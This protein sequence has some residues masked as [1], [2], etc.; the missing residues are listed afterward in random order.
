MHSAN[1]V[2]RFVP[3]ARLEDGAKLSRDVEDVPALVHGAEDL[4]WRDAA[5]GRLIGLEV[6]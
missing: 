5:S 6:E 3:P 4:L 2:K 1:L